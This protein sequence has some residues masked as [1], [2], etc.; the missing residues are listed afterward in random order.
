MKTTLSI[1]IL[2][3]AGIFGLHAQTLQYSQA[4]IVSNTMQTVPA[5]KVWKV[6]SVYGDSFMCVSPA[7]PY[8]DG[9]SSFF[10]T[11]YASYVGSGFKVN[12]NPVFSFRTWRGNTSSP[13]TSIRIFNDNACTDEYSSY[14]RS[15][16]TYD[17][18]PNP[19]LFPLWIPENSTL[20][21]NASTIFVSVLEFTVVP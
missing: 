14:T 12:G 9:G 19:N 3:L 6:T 18:S 16:S 1:S 20:Q 8:V 10:N 4:L 2:L 15:A 5:G 21:S 7:T 11:K 17:I 13:L